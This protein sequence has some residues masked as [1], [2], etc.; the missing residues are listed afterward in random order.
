MTGAF[1][2]YFSKR[3]AAATE[4]AAVMLRY[5]GFTPSGERRW[6]GIT[7][8]GNS[9]EVA[10]PAGFPDELPEVFMAVDAHRHVAHVN[11][12]GKVCIAPESG[13]LLDTTR[14]EDIVK[15]AI[16]LADSILEAKP[17]DQAKDILREYESYWAEFTSHIVSICPAKSETG[18]CWELELEASPPMKLVA[19]TSE[20][21][22]KWARATGRK[23]MKQTSAFLIRLPKPLQPPPYGDR[24]ALREILRV[25]QEF[26]SPEAARSLKGWLVKHGLPATLLISAPLEGRDDIVVAIQVPELNTQ[27]AARAQKGFRPGRVP[28]LRTVAQAAREPVHRIDVARADPDF[29]LPRGG[30]VPELL[31]RTVAVIGCGSVGS[32]AAGALAASGI[33]HLV[34]VDPQVLKTENFQRHLLGASSVGESKVTALARALKARYPHIKIT[35]IN[36]E[37]QES[38]D[39]AD[40]PVL[41]ADLVLCALGEEN[42]EL[43]LNELLKRRQRCVHVWLD[44]LGVGGHVLRSGNGDSPGCFRCL[45]NSDAAQG[46]VNMA[47]LVAPGQQFQRSIAGCSGTFTPFGAL[48]A[49]R[50]GIETA[51]EVIACLTTDSATARLNTW[52]VSKDAITA[53]GFSLSH[54]CETLAEGALVRDT[55]FPR[56][57]CPACSRRSA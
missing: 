45:F 39:K 3:R 1:S 41:A 32:F 8:K 30:A 40:S 46:L 18:E 12:S 9:I 49:E 35:E 16:A 51:R 57:D 42:L 38:L 10:L 21:A 34:L 27:A 44:P 26:G 17:D 48:D 11:R 43:Q 29:L 47:S 4:A 22:W 15:D 56:A 7:L 6:K 53:A 33:G 36:A 52:V 2:D 19:R 54:R 24:V 28:P 14:P 20:A 50:A 13:T 55:T 23:V 37:V 25:I 31:T 5:A